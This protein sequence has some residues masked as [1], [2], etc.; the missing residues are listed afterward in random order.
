MNGLNAWDF[1]SGDPYIPPNA[2]PKH[3]NVYKALLTRSFTSSNSTQTVRVDDEINT[4]GLNLN[5]M[6]EEI[7]QMHYQ[8]NNF[9]HQDAH[10]EI[11]YQESRI[12]LKVIELCNEQGITVLPIHDSMIVKKQHKQTLE[13]MM[14]EAYEALGFVSVPKVTVG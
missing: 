7:W 14:V 3:R 11:T 10:K 13:D 1:I 4:N 6:L 5:D 9:R 12:C 2:D 8:I